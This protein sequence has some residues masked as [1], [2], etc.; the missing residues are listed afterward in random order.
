MVIVAIVAVA[1]IAC[2]ALVTLDRDHV[3]GPSLKTEVVIGDYITFEYTEYDRGEIAAHYLN[4]YKVV[5]VEGDTFRVRCD[6]FGTITY[7][8]MDTKRFLNVAKIYDEYIEES[9]FIGMEDV[10]TPW[11]TIRCE[12]YDHDYRGMTEQTYIGPDD[13]I[14]R[15]YTPGYVTIVLKETSL[16]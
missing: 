5:S 15:A 10:D 11:G 1:I 16:L 8:Y 9:T 6:T 14:Y 7:E 13:V 4:Q 3:E 12:R 2:A